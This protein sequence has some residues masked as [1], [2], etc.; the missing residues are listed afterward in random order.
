MS[1][2]LESLLAAAARAKASDVH[3]VAGLPPVFRV[4]GQLLQY[5]SDKPPLDEATVEALVLPALSETAR[6]TLTSY[7]SPTAEAVVTL[8]QHENL[9][10]SLLVFRAKGGL[11]ATIRI[12][13]QHIPTLDEIGGDKAALLRDLSHTKRGLILFTGPTGSGK[14]T[15]AASFLDHINT[16]RSER[17]YVLEEI[18]GYS[19]RAKHSL[20]STLTIG[21]EYDSYE[22]AAQTLMR[23]AD[24]DIVLFSDLPTLDAVRQ[25]LILADTGHLVIAVLHGESAA[26]T[27]VDLMESFEKAQPGP[28]RAQFARSLVAVWNQRLLVRASG[29]GRTPVYEI[30][31]VT[32]AI[33]RHIVNGASAADLQTA[34]ESAPE[35]D[36]QWPLSAALDALVASGDVSESVADQYRTNRPEPTEPTDS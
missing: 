36:Q 21:Q 3:L 10:F 7:D 26:Q 13:S 15:T 9:D 25:A 20:I 18:A 23:G 30:L 2:T 24:P 28:L 11:A 35:S 5:Q 19:F 22:R 34:M 16:H 29:Q 31:T 6:A 33:Q 27:V 17:I 32:P 14:M 12:V 8:P 4:N 1:L